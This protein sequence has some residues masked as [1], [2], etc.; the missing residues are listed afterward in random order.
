MSPPARL[1]QPQACFLRALANGGRGC[2]E[3]GH[4]LRRPFDARALFGDEDDVEARGK[5]ITVATERLADASLD[6]VAM[7]RVPDLLGDRDSETGP[8]IVTR[9]EDDEER[10]GVDPMPAPLSFTV[11]GALPQPIVP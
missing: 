1:V 10:A 9:A 3:L 5:E 6:P 7:H 2:F 4:D 11:L 8:P